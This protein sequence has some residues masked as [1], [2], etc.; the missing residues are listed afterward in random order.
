M[1]MVRSLAF[2]LPASE[3]DSFGFGATGDAETV[4][5][6]AQESQRRFE[7]EKERLRNKLSEDRIKAQFD[8]YY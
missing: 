8:A 1:P 2:E 6:H 3:A 7:D 5:H 4:S